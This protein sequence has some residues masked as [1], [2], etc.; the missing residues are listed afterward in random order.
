MLYVVRIQAQEKVR[1]LWDEMLAEAGA[2]QDALGENGRLLYMSRRHLHNEAS[3]VV[4][5]VTPDALAEF[6]SGPLARLKD[7]TGVW[8]IQLFMPKFLTVPKGAEHLPRYAVTVKVFPS[9]LAQVYGKIASGD[10]PEGVALGYVA[11]TFHLLGDCLQFSVFARDEA[12]LSGHL[13]DKVRRI[14]GV[15]NLTMGRIVETQSLLSPA[16]WQRFTEEHA[17]SDPE[18]RLAGYFR[19]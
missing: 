9:A 12:V 11:Y 4:H 6:V 13:R 14:P 8:L 17:K 3:L 5:V 10:W 19:K 2:L 18:S 16:E 7:I 15:L 1:S